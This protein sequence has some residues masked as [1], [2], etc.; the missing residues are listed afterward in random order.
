MGGLESWIRL[1]ASVLL[2]DSIEGQAQ[3]PISHRQLV[4]Y[5]VS[6]EEGVF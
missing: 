6:K 2:F 1:D 3:L 5:V 4:D